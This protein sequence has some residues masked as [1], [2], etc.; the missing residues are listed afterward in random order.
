MKRHN[1]FRKWITGLLTPALIISCGMV[2]SADENSAASPAAFSDISRVS[3]HD[4]SIIQS[5][6]GTYYVLG[7]H[8]ASAKSEDLISWTQVNTDYGNPE[9]TPFFG[10]LAQNLAEPFSWAGYLDGD[11][12]HGYAVWAPDII[13][14]PYYQ[15]EDGSTGAYMLYCCTSSTWRRSA[16][17]Y[18]V[19]KE[20]N[21]TYKYADTI[22]YSGFTKTGQPDGN[23]TRNTKWDNDYLNLAELIEKGSANGGIDAVSDN[24]FTEDGGWNNAY[25]PNAIDPNLFFDASGETLYMSYGSWSGGMFLLELDRTTGASLYPGVDSIDEVS[26]NFVDRYFGTH[27]IGGN[28]QSGEAPY[29]RYDAETGYYYLY[30]SYGSLVAEGGYNIRLFRSASPTGPYLDAAGNNAADNNRK[31]D[32]YGIKL[33][34]NYRF[35][36]QLG[37][38]SAGHNSV[39]TDSD[40]SHYIVYHQRFDTEPITEAHEVRVHQQF[41]NEDCWPVT[42]V[43]EYRGE[44]PE[45]YETSELVG[46]YEFVNHGKR[47]AGLMLLTKS[48]T[49]HEDGTISGAA[50]GTWAASD[51]GK[52]YDYVTLTMDNGSV[53]KGIFFRQHKENEE[54]EAVMTFTAIGSDNISI[55]GS[56]ITTP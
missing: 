14:N 23:S 43:Y 53:Y 47:T 10:I 22:I 54:E 18:L 6:D 19:S 24:W 45:H 7:S 21:G 32:S 37:K 20:F 41:M 38:R 16:I 36:D 2:S 50:D 30:V 33:M 42:A 44:T 51:S 48:L 3:V 34:G 35:A 56:M 46:T 26:G 28:H 11:A 31:N 5:D 40:G 55:W 29:I 17:C 27:L 15:W 12:A 9:Q 13:W 1:L 25:A 49:L 4:P 39:F 52:G 8:T